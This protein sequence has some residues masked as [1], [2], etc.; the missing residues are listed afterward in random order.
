MAWTYDQLIAEMH[1]RHSHGQTE[2]WWGRTDYNSAQADWGAGDDHA[3]LDH[4]LDAWYHTNQAVEDA[5][6]EG[7]YGYNGGTN[8]LPTALDSA[9]ACEFIRECPPADPFVLTMSEILDAL[10]DAQPHQCLLFIPM[11]DAMRG[12]IQEKTVTQNW[13]SNALRRFL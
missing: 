5:L 6:A 9:M 3:C 11:I 1:T 2:L 10:W 7:F 4:L 8:I 12:A 13:M